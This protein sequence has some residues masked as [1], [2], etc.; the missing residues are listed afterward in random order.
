MV[1]TLQR[2]LIKA[3]IRVLDPR[4]KGWFNDVTHPKHYVHGYESVQHR[5]KVSKVAVPSNLNDPIRLEYYYFFVKDDWEITFLR[6][7]TYIQ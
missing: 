4:G 2:R 5:E 6:M 7:Q 3:L 1:I